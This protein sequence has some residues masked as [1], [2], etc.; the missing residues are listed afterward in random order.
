MRDPVGGFRLLRKMRER[1]THGGRG[2][3]PCQECLARIFDE[4]PS[5]VPRPSRGVGGARCDVV[6][7]IPVSSGALSRWGIVI[8]RSSMIKDHRLESR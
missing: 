4:K 8:S 1:I 5:T 7:S 3:R 2:L 6:V